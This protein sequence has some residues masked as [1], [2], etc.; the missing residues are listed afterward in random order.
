MEMEQNHTSYLETY[1]NLTTYLSLSKII[2]L[3]HDF[4]NRNFSV[5]WL[6]RTQ[7]MELK[8]NQAFFPG[9]YSHNTKIFQ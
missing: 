4:Q 2:K 9:T 3:I 5:L 7:T 6:K 8:Q 1:S